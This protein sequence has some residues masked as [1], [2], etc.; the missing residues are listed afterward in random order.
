LEN[1]RANFGIATVVQW[2]KYLTAVA[3]VSV[4]AWVPSPA[5]HSGLKGLALLQLQLGFNLCSP[6]FL[7]AL[8]A[9]IQKKKK[10]KKRER[11]RARKL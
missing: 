10:K 3:Q 1:R 4:E 8:S 7:Y 11:E 9:A 6:E 2:F 5:Q